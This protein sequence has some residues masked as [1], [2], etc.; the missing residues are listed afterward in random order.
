MYLVSVNKKILQFIGHFIGLRANCMREKQQRSQGYP[1]SLFCKFF[2]F[3]M[4]FC[5]DNLTKYL[6]V[7][8]MKL[9][10]FVIRNKKVLYN[11]NNFMYLVNVNKKILQFIG[12]FIGLRADCMREKQQRSQITYVIYIFYTYYKTR[13]VSL[14]ANN[15]VVLT[16][17]FVN[18]NKEMSY[19]SFW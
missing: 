14:F 5:V 18:K 2:V 13:E 6:I 15:L 17:L 16:K 11:A 12:H 19:F 10:F 9:Q 3:N 7:A 4:F 1:R 8:I